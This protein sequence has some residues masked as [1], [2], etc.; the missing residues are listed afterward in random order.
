[1]GEKKPNAWGLYDMHGNVWEWCWDW[2]DG[3]Y[4]ARSP[5]DD[6]TGPAGGSYHLSRG[7]GWIYPAEFC[8][9]ACRYGPGIR[10]YTLGFRV[11]LVPASGGQVNVP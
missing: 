11:A 1:V 6:P 7:G 8:R 9:S 3:G 10:E 5:T 2:C 4:Y